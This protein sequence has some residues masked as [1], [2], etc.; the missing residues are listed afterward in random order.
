M[1]YA[2][3]IYRREDDSDGMSDEE[4][5]SI[6]AEYMAI[7]DDPRVVGGAALYPNESATILRLGEGGE[8]LI[9]DGPYADTKEVLGGFYLMQAD[10][11]D[12]A[13]E[14]AARIPAARLGGT[15]EVRPIVEYP[16]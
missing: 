4:Q 9:T 12:A 10:D 2:L 7:R 16:R 8:A 11:I 5:K 14:I 3:L 15:I 1:Q 13:L 6:S